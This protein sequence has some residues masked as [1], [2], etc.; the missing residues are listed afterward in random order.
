MLSSEQKNKAVLTDTLRIAEVIILESRILKDTGIKRNSQGELA[1]Q[2]EYYDPMWQ[3]NCIREND[4]T[5]TASPFQMSTF[6]FSSKDHD[7]INI[8][9]CS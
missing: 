6:K 3:T 4:F 5:L 7:E 2:K 9:Q 1:M 8:Q